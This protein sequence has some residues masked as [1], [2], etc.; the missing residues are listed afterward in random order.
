MAAE[1]PNS[2]IADAL[3]ELG[4][5]YELDGAIVHRVLAYRAAARSVREAPVSVAELARAGRATVILTVSPNLK[6]GLYPV[7][8]EVRADDGWVGR[9]RVQHLASG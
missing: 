6:H 5:L 4:D 7:L 2:A 9:F 3:E 1:L 8:V